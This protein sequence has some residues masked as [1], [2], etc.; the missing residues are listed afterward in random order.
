MTEMKI[1]GRREVISILDLELYNLD[2][3][4][5]ARKSI[6]KSKFRFFW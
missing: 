2:A 1:V 5:D 6:H 4:N 3:W